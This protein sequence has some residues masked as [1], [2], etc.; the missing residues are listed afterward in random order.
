MILACVDESANKI[1]FTLSAVVLTGA[2]AK[3]LGDELDAIVSSLTQFGVPDGAELHGHELFHGKGL[4]RNVPVRLRIG[5]YAKAPR[6]VG[7][8]DAKLFFR[9]IDNVGQAARYTTPF[10]AHEVALQY[11]LEDLNAYARIRD[12]QVLV[13]ADEVHTESRHRTNFRSFK[14]GGTPGYRSTRLGS[15]LDTIYFGPSDHSR[16]LQAADL[17]TFMYLR[18]KAVVETDPRAARANES[19]WEPLR[20]ITVKDL[21]SFGPNS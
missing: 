1:Y 4:W 11:L 6:A 10:P 13:L 16:L 17:A 9:C 14:A 3:Q 8:S 19:I 15:I 12:E 21:T 18:R 20:R 7:N 2:A 5:I